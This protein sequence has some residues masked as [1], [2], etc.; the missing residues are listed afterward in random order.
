MIVD[1]EQEIGPMI[2]LF[3]PARPF[4]SA[5]CSSPEGSCTIPGARP[6]SLPRSS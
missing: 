6:S 2:T 3:C 4:H 5:K 1:E